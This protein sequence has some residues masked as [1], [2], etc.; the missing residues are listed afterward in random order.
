MNSLLSTKKYLSQNLL[1]SI[2]KAIAYF[3]DA[4][5]TE[6]AVSLKNQTWDSAKKIIQKSIREYLAE[7][8]VKEISKW[9]SVD[10]YQP[11]FS[12]MPSFISKFLLSATVR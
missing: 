8:A 9:L 7:M 12:I 3:D 2:P 6:D 1:I 4:E 5:E 11:F 10:F